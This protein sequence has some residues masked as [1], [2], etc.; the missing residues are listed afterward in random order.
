MNT[1]CPHGENAAA[2]LAHELPPHEH[3]EFSRHLAT[4]ATCQAGV[5]SM[6]HLLGRLRAVPVAETARDL[7]PEIFAR[8]RD[9]PR[10]LPRPSLW[11]QLTAIAAAVAL[12]AGG[13][14]LAPWRSP[15]PSAPSAP[16]VV[17]ADRM[18]PHISRALDW[19]CHTQ[20]ADGSWDAEKWGGSSHFAVALTALP[21]LALLSS[22]VRTP[23]REAA[24]A[25][26]ARWLQEQQDET[27]AFGPDFQGA[28]YNQGMATL[29]LLRAYQRHPDAGLK[30][31]LDAALR[32]IL[33]RQTPAGGWGYRHSPMADRS[34][35]EWHVDA[36][37]IARPVFLIGWI[38]KPYLEV[39]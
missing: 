32:T 10:A 21:T 26:A 4:C 22:D 6:R 24:L 13:A 9:E 3:A 14:L 8:L 27:G 39:M 28:S 2:F 36:L 23:E 7:A 35:T 1:D 17:A 33:A 19:F 15:A 37:E 11:P 29:A 25:N 12:L 18:D 31:T 5:A 38:R 30:R 34:I 20:E 16:A